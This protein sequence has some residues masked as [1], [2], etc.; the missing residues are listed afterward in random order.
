MISSRP[1][2][3][4]DFIRDTEVLNEAMLPPLFEF[5]TI[6][7]YFMDAPDDESGHSATLKTSEII[8]I[9]I[10]DKAQTN[11]EGYSFILDTGNSKLHLNAIYKFEM[12]RW[13]EAIV[14]SM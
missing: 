7:Q 5:D 3:M 6:Y 8:S 13:V 12:E 10:K 2:G 14:I 11:E 4:E 9:K 1:L